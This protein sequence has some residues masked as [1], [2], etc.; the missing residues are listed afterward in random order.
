VALFQDPAFMV[1]ADGGALDGVEAGARFD[2]MLHRA[3]LPP[4][5]K[6]PVVE[7]STGMIVGY[8]GADVM[9]VDGVVEAEFG[10]RLVAD[11]RGRGY[12]SEAGRALLG[13]TR[14]ER[15]IVVIHADNAASIRTSEKLGF[16][17]WKWGDVGGER[18]YIGLLD[19]P[20][21][22]GTDGIAPTGTAAHSTG[23]DASPAQRCRAALPEQRPQ[24]SSDNPLGTRRLRRAWR[25]GSARG[26]LGTSGAPY[27][28]RA[29]PSTECP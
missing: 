25:A 17:R 19:G 21:I 28:N 24:V 6:R 16:R 11:E 27:G 5:S 20:T 10:Y 2:R 15:L 13:S 7:R 29:T 18:R 3:E 8:V 26:R 4:I 23:S 9:D 22:G 1:F 14:P 12:A